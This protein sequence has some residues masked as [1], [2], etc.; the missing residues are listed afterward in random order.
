MKSKIVLDT[1]CLLS[2][3]SRRGR[4]YSVWKGL[5]EGKYILYV[6]TEIILE[7]QEIISQKTNE[8]IANNVIQTILN[9]K[10]V[11]CIEPSYHMHLIEQDN[12]DNKFVDCA[13]AAGASFIVSND[14]HYNILETIP[15][16]KVD[17]I[18]LQE[19]VYLLTQQS[20]L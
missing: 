15:F 14:K 17:V 18:S 2:S 5:Q 20:N 3:L 6:S 13:I 10:N 1:N 4:Y 19:F 9:C 7:Y 16:P 8:F 11:V 12:D